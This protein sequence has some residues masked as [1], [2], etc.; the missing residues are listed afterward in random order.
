MGYICVQRNNDSAH[1]CIPP[2]HF[3]IVHQYRVAC[4]YACLPW[5]RQILV[6]VVGACPFLLQ[7]EKSSKTR[8]LSF[9][10]PTNKRKGHPRQALLREQGCF[11]ARTICI[12]Q[13]TAF[14]VAERPP[15]SPS[16]IARC[17]FP[18]FGC[19]L[20]QSR[21][22]VPATCAAL[23]TLWAQPAHFRASFPLLVYFTQRRK[24]AKTQ[25]PRC[26]ALRLCAFA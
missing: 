19:I 15:K 26:L 10:R 16:F 1:P 23:A 11:P 13:R 25:S 22:V 7:Q 4:V 18:R 14:V 8:C 12:F 21:C 9:G 5:A 17:H 3:D 2:C 6:I 20:L 24:G